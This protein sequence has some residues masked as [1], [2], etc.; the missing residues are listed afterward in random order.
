MNK[1]E[2]L[3]EFAPNH[4][5]Q[6]IINCFNE[7]F[8]T[9]VNYEQIRYYLRKYKIKPLVHE[10]F[11][12]RYSHEEIEWIRNNYD[13]NNLHKMV[14][15]F[16]KLFNYNLS[17]TTFINLCNRH[18]IKSYSLHK[19]SKQEE[20][21]IKNNYKNYIQ[22]DTFITRLFI[23]DFEK[24]FGFKINNKYLIK[25][26]KRLGI[27]KPRPNIGLERCPIG[28]EKKTNYGTLIK[29][30]NDI[31]SKEHRWTNGV[32][33]QTFN[34]RKKA[35]V[36]YE[37]YHNVKINDETHIV[38]H[39]DNNNENFDKDNLYLINRKAFYIYHNTRY[40]NQT[41]ETKLNALKISEIQQLIKEIE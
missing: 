24:E 17:Y 31:P 15:E 23:N 5:M 1:I 11:I 10:K 22:K 28:F 33:K 21:W 7:Q 27:E 25:L 41:L 9:D 36:L 12:K 13:S 2:W 37:Q 4:Y 29:V 16:N 14:K 20:E 8:D 6:E 26:F 30:S 40:N 19:Y 35:H 3:K 34:Y 39:L 18:N 32:L 38:I